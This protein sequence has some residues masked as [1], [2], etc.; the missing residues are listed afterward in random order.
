MYGLLRVPRRVRLRRGVRRR[1]PGESSGDRPRCGGARQTFPDDLLVR[2]AD[3]AD[4]IVLGSSFDRS[5]DYPEMQAA[6]LAIKQANDS[7]GLAGVEFALVQCTYA[8]DSDFDGLT[9]EEATAET[10]VRLADALGAHAIVGPAT[11]GM[12]EAAWNAV[13]DRALI[14]SPSAEPRAHLDR[15]RRE[16][17]RRPRPALA[18]R[19]PG[20]PAGAGARG[21]RGR[22]ARQRAAHRGRDPP[23][24][25]LRRR[26]R[27]G[28][29]RGPPTP[30][31]RP[32]STPSRTTP[33][34]TPR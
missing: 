10:A 30:A 27:G 24:G 1:R 2:P 34:A 28:L 31:A 20:L 21:R 6:R 14:I 33:S 26:A 29:P 7:G 16:D 15:R 5:T 23:G 22:A 9:M 25:A 18:H 17:R 11:S 19:A 4:V 13:G 8:E 32:I 12:T 3:Y